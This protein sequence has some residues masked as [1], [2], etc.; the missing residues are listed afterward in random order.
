M[1]GLGTPETAIFTFV[2][3]FVPLWVE[4]LKVCQ[5]VPQM[6][7]GGTRGSELELGTFTHKSPCQVR[8][9]PTRGFWTEILFLDRNGY[10][11]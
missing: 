5:R 2:L 3:A 10:Y 6:P 4:G 8:V 9:A 7:A 11:F 1:N